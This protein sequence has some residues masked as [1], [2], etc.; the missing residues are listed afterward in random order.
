MILNFSVK[1][2]GKKRAHI[3]NL[4]IQLNLNDET[5]V[6]ELLEQLV[7]QQVEVF[8]KRI[9]ENNLFDFLSDEHISKSS[10]EGR[11]KFNETYN[12]KKADPIKALRVVNLAFEDGLIALFHNGNRL[13]SIDEVFNIQES[14]S[15]SII[16]LTFLAGSI[17]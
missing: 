7:H 10:L 3:D 12:D 17:W 14:D 1:S 13:E 11:V 5:S 6:A 2:L 9:G 15:I 16:R 4:S 8:N